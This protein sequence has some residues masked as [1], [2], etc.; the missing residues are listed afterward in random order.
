MRRFLITIMLLSAYAMN[1]TPASAL[2]ADDTMSAWRQASDKER[3]ELLKQ[4]DGGAEKAGLR[5]C[6][7]ETSKT[8]GHVDL[9]I[10]E[11]AKAC[12]AA[13]NADQPV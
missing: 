13:G 12:A 7:D 8:P 2:Q 1:I 11:V 4:L 9:A 6:M 5:R 10:A 3:S